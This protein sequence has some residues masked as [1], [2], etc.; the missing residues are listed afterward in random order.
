MHSLVG[1]V[2]MSI[3]VMVSVMILIGV[4]TRVKV[5]FRVMV[6][7]RLQFRMRFMFVVSGKKCR[8]LPL[9]HCVT[10]RMNITSVSAL[11]QVRWHPQCDKQ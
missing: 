2:R 9:S 1:E 8:V 3:R 6:M 10:A 11:C 5:R 7:H 4:S